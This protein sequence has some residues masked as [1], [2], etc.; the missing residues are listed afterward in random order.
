MR[1][2][3]VISFVVSLVLA[4]CSRANREP[5][6]NT[7]STPSA[8]AP[9][10]GAPG[11]SGALAVAYLKKLKDASSDVRP[12]QRSSGKYR[13]LTSVGDMLMYAPWL[14]RS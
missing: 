8:D 7:K 12:P 9:A 14:F 3:M 4:G 10:T 5:T 6:G 2:L 11:A 1:S 13:C